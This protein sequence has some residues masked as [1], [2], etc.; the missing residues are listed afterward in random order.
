MKDP[1]SF[2]IHTVIHNHDSVLRYPLGKIVEAFLFD[3]EDRLI[4]SLLTEI[5]FKNN[6]PSTDVLNDPIGFA[7]E[8]VIHR[9]SNGLSETFQQTVLNLKHIHRVQ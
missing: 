4:S 5:N 3:C 7:C 2:F 8:K 1:S 6:V 9:I